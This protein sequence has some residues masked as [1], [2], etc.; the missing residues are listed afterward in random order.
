MLRR[1]STKLTLA[2]SIAFALVMS[3]NAALRVQRQAG[4]F[5][6]DIRNDHAVLGRAVAEATAT[7]AD[8]AGLESALL[9]VEEANARR[10]HLQL[11]WVIAGHANDR[12]VVVEA[13]EGRMLVTHVP[14]Q[15]ASAP[16]GYI[17]LTESL[18]P[19]ERYVREMILRQTAATLI[20]IL[21]CA[22]L[23][24]VAGAFILARP[25][26]PILAKIQ[27]V[28]EGDLDGPLQL[29]RNDELGIIAKELDQMCERLAALQRQAAAETDARI[30]AMEQLRHAD[31]L[32]TVGKLASG[33][34]HELGTPLNVVAARA[35]MIERGES[36]GQE[37]VND[38]RVIGAQTERMARIIRQLLDFARRESPRRE[39]ADL[40]AAAASVL[41]LLRPLA[42]AREVSL[43]L[44]DGVPVDVE[45]D[46]AQVQ[47]VITN[48]VMN[49]I[50]AQPS[51]GSVEVEV[52]KEAE[53]ARIVVR[54]RG[55]GIA[56]DVRD[57]IFE[58]FFTTKELGTGTGL[59]L[60]VVH[61]IV[62]EHGGHV[63]VESELGEGTH[64]AVELPIGGST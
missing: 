41:S 46:V 27:R 63:L 20:A 33:V 47:Q 62:A 50:Q 13:P 26:R 53:T 35:K 38:A 8:Q 58:P 29:R 60:S 25:L 32:G 39:P 43:T 21:V 57:R 11:R 37:I 10:A 49:A 28:G 56:Q 48:L 1:I 14:V 40:R 24:H 44:R 17:E 15:T 12:S 22:A 5:E 34:A 54:D 7:L 4:I 61:G 2:A 36:E 42:T 6:D 45:V 3:A 31:R 52:E 59:G 51:G 30:A 23:V 19:Q 9:A 64:F 18:A 16:T 55:P